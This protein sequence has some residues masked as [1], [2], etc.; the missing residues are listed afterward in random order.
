MAE[1]DVTDGVPEPMQK[2]DD[3][4]SY[5]DLLGISRAATEQEVGKAYKKLAIKYHPD[6]NPG[7][8]EMAAMTTTAE[9]LHRRPQLRQIR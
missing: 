2:L 6:K 9:R 8:T 3:K 5:Y 4:A 7:E 1:V